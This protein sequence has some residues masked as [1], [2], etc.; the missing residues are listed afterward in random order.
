MVP[1]ANPART[2]GPLAPLD[3]AL[4]AGR[5]ILVAGGT[6][7]IGTALADTLARHGAA[8]VLHSHD[9]S[10][11]GPALASDLTR[12]YGTRVTAVHGDVTEPDQIA[13]LRDRL[14]EAGIRHLD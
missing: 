10:P 9:Q 7:A 14:T 5:T 1:P 4:L 6:G 2:A 13:R 12:Q 3:S 11:A 8:L